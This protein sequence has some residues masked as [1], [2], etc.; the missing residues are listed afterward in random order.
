MLKYILND[1]ESNQDNVTPTIRNSIISILNRYI[2][3]YQGPFFQYLSQIY[4]DLNIFIEL[5]FKNMDFLTSHTALYK[6][7]YIEKSMQLHYY[8]WLT[9]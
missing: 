2:I 5:Y 4:Q 9:H 7:Y 1:L 8:H 6:F 3:L